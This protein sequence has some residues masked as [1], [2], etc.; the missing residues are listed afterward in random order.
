MITEEPQEPEDNDRDI[1]V[2]NRDS[3]VAEPVSQ[4]RQHG[5]MRKE[6]ESQ[7]F[8]EVSEYVLCEWAQ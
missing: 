4:E 2:R 6:G 8:R 1:T 5:V 3:G 7:T